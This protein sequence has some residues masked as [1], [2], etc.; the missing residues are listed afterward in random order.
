MRTPGP[1]AQ[2]DLLDQLSQRLGRLH[3]RQ[4]LGI[5]TDHEQRIFGGG[6]NFFHPEN[7]YSAP[8][9]VGA[10]LKL[11]GLYWRGRRNA[12][13]SELRHHLVRR[14]ELP[15]AFDGYS[16]LHLS[17]RHVDIS[18]GAMRRLKAMVGDRA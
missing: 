9:F 4:R 6:L 3:A 11:S 15:A 1:S 18:P 12:E 8:V 14:P 7:W 10:C 5:E 13:R 2:R 17:D 16:I